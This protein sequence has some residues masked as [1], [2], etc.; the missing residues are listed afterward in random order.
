MAGGTGTLGTR[1]VRALSASGVPVRVLTRSADRAGGLPAEIVVGDVRDPATLAQ[2][3]RG[4]TTVVSAVQGFA[5]TDPGGATAVDLRGNENLLSAAVAAGAERF[6][7]ISAAGAAPDSSLD[8]RR[9]KH[10]AETTALRS[11]LKTTIIRPTVY[12][13]TWLGILTEMIEAKR[14]VTIFGRGDNPINFVSADD[15]AALV[16]HATRS[17]EL[18]GATLEIGGPDNLTLNELARAVLARHGVPE[19]VSHVPLLV[20]RAVATLARP[21]KPSIAALARFG[22][23]MDSTDMTLAADTARA[24]VPGLPLTSVADVIA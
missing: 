6:V 19:K 17:P 2:A 22:V 18:A 15:V 14:A 13:E 9:I 16:E 4:V 7:L 20:V 21:V 1:A 10:Q 23:A 11:E 5:G 8:L 3:M 24:Q 12:L